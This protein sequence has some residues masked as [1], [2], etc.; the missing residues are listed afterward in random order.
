MVKMKKYL[1]FIIYSIPN[2]IALIKYRPKIY[3]TKETLEEIIKNKKSISRFGDGEINLILGKENL[4]QKY[5]KELSLRLAKILKNINVNENNIVAIPYVWR[6]N[7][8]EYTFSSIKFWS[9][10]L[11]KNYK[12][13]YSLLNLDY[14]YY[15]AQCTRVYINRKNKE[16]AN[17]Y[18]DLWKKIWDEKDVLIVEG[19][20][21]RMGIGNDLLSNA[22]TVRRILCPAKNSYNKYNEIKNAILKN[23]KNSLV[24][25]LLGATA[26]VLSYE[27]STEYK[28]QVIDLGNLDTEY[29][30]S[31]RNVKEKVIISGKSTYE[32]DIEN[33]YD[34]DDEKYK[35]EIILK[36]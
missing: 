29:E 14:K 21:S 19:E 1:K 11:L 9:I 32:C 2:L 33:N 22:K 27:L 6:G 24:L 17:K 35:N 5:N 4:S 23:H 18:F 36:I 3:T 10:Y 26:T 13:I 20:F 15:D 25:L 28:I 31:K 7:F 30:W 12:K 16:D 34:L 8:N